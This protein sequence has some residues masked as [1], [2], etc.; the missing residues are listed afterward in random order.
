[1]TYSRAFPNLPTPYRRCF[2][3][4]ERID[5]S[6]LHH[7]ALPVT[8]FNLAGATCRQGDV[9][10]RIVRI[11]DL[12]GDLLH[13][14]P[15]RACAGAAGGPPRAPAAARSPGTRYGLPYGVRGGPPA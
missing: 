11:N 2:A 7:K 8:R 15:S 13:E 12:I 9:T 3:A 6:Q 10:H 1:S 4:R 5:Q 14:H